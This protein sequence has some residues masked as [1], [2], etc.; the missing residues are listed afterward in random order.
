LGDPGIALMSNIVLNPTAVSL[1]GRGESDDLG[2][3]FVSLAESLTG[4]P[5]TGVATTQDEPS[6]AEHHSSRI[7]DGTRETKINWDNGLDA[8]DHLASGP[9]NGSQE[10]LDDFLN[11]LGQDQSQ[12]NPNAGIR[13][14]PM[15]VSVAG[16][17]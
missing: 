12:W 6:G 15:S 7:V 16:Q 10:W 1:R 9:S 8:V 13:V 4:G 2:K 14:R 11:H 5:T 17:A 3:S